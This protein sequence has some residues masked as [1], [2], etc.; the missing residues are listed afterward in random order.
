MTEVA[1][2]CLQRPSRVGGSVS[3][4]S[5]MIFSGVPVVAQG[6][7]LG[8][9]APPPFYVALRPP[10]FLPAVWSIGRCL[11]RGRRAS[12][13]SRHARGHH[14][15][16]RHGKYSCTA[17]A[18]AASP[19]LHPSLCTPSS[20]HCRVVSLPRAR[21]ETSHLH[22]PSPEPGPGSSQQGPENNSAKG[23]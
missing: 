1:L 4:G 19:S 22:I 7:G 6:K 11:R 2:V 12:R 10:Q 13:Q 23:C 16:V 3:L 18:P 20:L 8:V 21:K 17:G 5:Q 15:G 14:P 9:R